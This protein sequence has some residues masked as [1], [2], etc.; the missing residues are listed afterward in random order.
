MGWPMSPPPGS[1]RCPPP[2]GGA[3]ETKGG[4][5]GRL[6]VEAGAPPTW[7]SLALTYQGPCSL[8]LSDS[9]TRAA[10]PV[11]QIW[12]GCA[13]LEN[14]PPNLPQSCGKKPYAVLRLR[15]K[16]KKKKI[17]FFSFGQ[18]SR[19]HFEPSPSSSPLQLPT[20]SFQ[21]ILESWVAFMRWSDSIFLY[22]ITL[23]NLNKIFSG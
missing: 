2:K 4:N 6:T 23:Y 15:I 8:R 5:S 18:G 16:K 14:T 7:G 19:S 21:Q 13:D 20:M 1:G 22:F 3:E 12:N 11:S 9:L 10:W 17:S